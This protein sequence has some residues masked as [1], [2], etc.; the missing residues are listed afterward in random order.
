MDEIVIDDKKFKLSIPSHE[1]KSAIIELAFKINRDFKD[2]EIYFIAVLDGAFMFAADFI[3]LV[4]VP[5][6]I[7]FIK[8]KSYAGIESTGNVKE[9]IGLEDD[10]KGK[11]VVILEDIV[12]TGLTLKTLV[13]NISKQR[14]DI[15]KIAAMFYKADA[16]KGDLTIDYFGINIPNRFVVGYGLDLNGYGRNLEHLYILDT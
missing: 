14:P 7:N 16:Y 2:T 15:I 6:R 8:T 3:K 1:I 13:E 10:L 4:T 5:C 12:D 9:L 11:T